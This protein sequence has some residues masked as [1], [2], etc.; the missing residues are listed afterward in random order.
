M[1]N[2]SSLPRNKHQMLSVQQK[3]QCVLQIFY[4]ISSC[5]QVHIEVIHVTHVTSRNVTLP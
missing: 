2:C 4:D 3:D 1:H 5:K